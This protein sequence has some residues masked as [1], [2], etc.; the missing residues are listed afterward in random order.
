[1]GYQHLIAARLENSENGTWAEPKYAYF[2][3]SS[4]GQ[5]E[6][7]MKN[8][9]SLGDPVFGHIVNICIHIGGCRF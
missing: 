6:I 1:M 9:F 5:N 3:A 7:I 8:I 2:M 4:R